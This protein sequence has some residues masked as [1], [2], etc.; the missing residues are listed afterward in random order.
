MLSPLVYVALVYSKANEGKC[1]WYNLLLFPLKG[2]RKQHETVTVW[3]KQPYKRGG[4]VQ[5]ISTQSNG[6]KG[7]HMYCLAHDL[8]PKCYSIK[9]QAPAWE[10]KAAQRIDDLLESFIGIRD[11]DLGELL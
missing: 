1:D 2:H 11:P 6:H 4:A 3:L 10:L 9:L 7:K 8:I 5:C